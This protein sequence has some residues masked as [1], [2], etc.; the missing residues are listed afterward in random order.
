MRDKKAG[1]KEYSKTIIPPPPFLW[2]LSYNFGSVGTKFS[3]DKKLADICYFSWT[4]FCYFRHYIY[5]F[6]AK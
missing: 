5:P 4:F 1:Y 2:F 3:K 6:F